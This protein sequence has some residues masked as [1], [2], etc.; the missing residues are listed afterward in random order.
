M[1]MRSQMHA[2]QPIPTLR[3]KRKICLEFQLITIVYTSMAPQVHDASEVRLVSDVRTNLG[4]LARHILLL[5]SGA[6]P[7]RIDENTSV[8]IYTFVDDDRRRVTQLGRPERQ[9]SQ[10]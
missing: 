4:K 7:D 6:C 5:L 8:N 1:L 10:R 2:E 3:C 9:T